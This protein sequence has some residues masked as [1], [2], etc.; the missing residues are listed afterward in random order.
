MPDLHWF[1]RC[2]ICLSTYSDCRT[3]CHASSFKNL[4][5]SMSHSTFI[6]VNEIV[7]GGCLLPFS[8]VTT[9]G[10]NKIVCCS[11]YAPTICISMNKFH[12]SITTDSMDAATTETNISFIM[13]LIILIF[14]VVVAVV[15]IAVVAD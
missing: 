6:Q 5:I 8:S 15:V 4:S 3:C 7:V 1:E 2:F 10:M 14:V 13:L 12:K 9:S 11:H